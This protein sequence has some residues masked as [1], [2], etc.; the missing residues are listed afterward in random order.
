TN[1]DS[2]FHLSQ[3]AHPLLKA[4][5][6][7][8]I[9]FIS[10]I[11]S[12]VG[13]DNLAVYAA[14]KGAMNQLTR[15]LACEW[16]K[17]N[18]RANCV[19]PGY[20]RTPLIEPVMDVNLAT[21]SF[22]CVALCLLREYELHV[23]LPGE[24]PY[25]AFLDGFTLPTDDL[26]V[27]FRFSLHPI[28][29]IGLDGW[30]ISPSQMGSNSWRYMVAFL[31]EFREVDISGAGSEALAA[32][33][34]RATDLE[35]KVERMKVALGD[36]E[37]WCKDLEH[38][39]DNTRRDLKDIRDNR[40]NMEDEML[41]LTQNAEALRSELH[42][43]YLVH[44]IGPDLGCGHLGGGDG[45]L[46]KPFHLQQA[47]HWPGLLWQGRRCQTWPDDL[48]APGKADMVEVTRDPECR[49]KR[50]RRRKTMEGA[51]QKCGDN[52]AA[53]RWT[54]VGTT[55]LVTGGTK[56]IGYRHLSSYI[57]SSA[58]QHKQVHTEI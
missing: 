11:T 34:K 32:V 53:G 41:K 15:S 55:A 37:Q 42:R 45:W 49:Q 21:F 14:T 50:S 2:A 29:E 6:S 40:R 48:E 38:A 18:I 25:D 47:P 39:T 20:I 10:S 30:Q 5:G 9:V 24:C 43:W 13:I 26:K 35:A 54:L 33:E 19:A 31:G 8:N 4:S 46:E 56:G 27:G 28:I 36:A 7:G 44:P 51:D 58:S 57:C 23:P 22:P 17:D 3:L 1:L 52:Q 12:L 16:A